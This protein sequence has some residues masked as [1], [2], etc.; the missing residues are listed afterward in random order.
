MPARSTPAL[1]TEPV[2]GITL[3]AYLQV[4]EKY[5]VLSCTIHQGVS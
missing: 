2:K 1:S 5:T 3:S 4:I